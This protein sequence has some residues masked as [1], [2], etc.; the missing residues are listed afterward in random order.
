MDWKKLGV[1]TQKRQ[2]LLRWFSRNAPSLGELYHGAVCIVFA[3]SFPG[4]VRFVSHAVREI[5]NRLPDV[6]AGPTD[7]KTLQYKNR[8]DQI[9]A[10]WET[11]TVGD[12]DP[13]SG[14]RDVRIPHNAYL[15]IQRL[16]EDHRRSRETPHAA[17]RRLYQAIDPSNVDEATLRPRITH[18]IQVTEWFVQRAHDRQ[19]IDAEMGAAELQQRFDTFECA[20]SAMLCTFFVAI[21]ELDEILGSAN[22]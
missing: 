22:T 18:W 7:A 5:R 13:F 21:G 6:I 15:L 2:E 12:Q 4:R 17:A 11:V 8:L 10:A 16:I 19:R 14:T 1:S 9:E 3:D 20:L